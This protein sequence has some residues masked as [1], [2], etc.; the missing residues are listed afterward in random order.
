MMLT[1]KDFR[2]V[3]PQERVKTET[4]R[5][6]TTPAGTSQRD[7]DAGRARPFLPHVFVFFFLS[8]FSSFFFLSF[9]PKTKRRGGK[10]K[11]EE[12]KRKGRKSKKRARGA[13]AAVAAA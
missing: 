11:R 12:Q 9:C 6:I 2:S 3:Q 8:L 7:E 4:C 13:T 10:R 1:S 5:P